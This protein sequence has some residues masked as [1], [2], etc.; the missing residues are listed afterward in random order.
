MQS[1]LVSAIIP[2]YN[3]SCYITKSIKSVLSQ[4]YQNIEIIV[5][6]DGSRDSTYE[7]IKPYLG[8]LKYIYQKNQGASAARNKGIMNSAGEYVAFLD[9]D[10]IWLPEKIEIQINQMLEHPEIGM[11]HSN[12]GFIDADDNHLD[13]I[14]W[15]IGAQGK[16][17]K[18][19]FIQNK[20]MILTVVIRRACLDR[21]GFFDEGI[22]YC[23]DR[24]LWLRLSHKFPIGYID[25]CLAYYRIHDSNMSHKRVEHFNYRLKMYKKMLRIYPDVWNTVGESDVI[26]CIFNDTY[27]LANLCYKSGNYQ[28]AVLYYLKAISWSPLEFL[29]KQFSPE[30]ANLVRWYRYKIYK[31]FQRAIKNFH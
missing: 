25:K 11:V 18:E 22:K 8:R 28:K 1:P 31:S 3:G 29:L 13:G 7:K 5:V 16:C 4:T 21:V 19:L 2:V 17:F 15:P 9:H 27:R 20:I 30:K 12:C 6:D 10:D 24:E 23:E 26:K 14:N